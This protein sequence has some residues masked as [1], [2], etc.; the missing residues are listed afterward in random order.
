MRAKD[1]VANQSKSLV[2]ISGIRTDAEIAALNASHPDF[3]GFFFTPSRWRLEPEAAAVLIGELGFSIRPVGIFADES[4]ERV[5]EV[6]GECGLHAVRLDG[7]EDAT[8][9]AA[10][11]KLLPVGVK[12]WKSLLV[13]PG[14]PLDAAGADLRTLDAST[15]GW[16][17][18]QSV[19]G[20]YLLTGGLTADRLKTALESLRP[21][22]VEASDGVEDAAGFKNAARIAAFVTVARGARG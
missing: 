19:D 9:V 15:S 4:A 13:V 7:H 22:A 20:P 3:A 5:A 10:L 12:V 8:Y 1:R 2:M 16:D 14:A 17:A 11:R 21:Y 18:L 6:A